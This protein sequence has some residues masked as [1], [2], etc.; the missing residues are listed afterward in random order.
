VFIDW[1]NDKD[2]DD[3]GELVATSASISATAAFTASVSVPAT[4]SLGA[5]RMR[6]VCTE[7][8]AASGVTACGT[9]SYGE[10]EDYSINI[11]EGT[12]T[13]APTVTSFTPASGAVGTSVTITGTNFTGA[14]AVR[15]NGTSATFTVASA[16][17]ITTSVPTGATTG[18]ISVTTA[19]GTANSASNFTVTAATYCA[20]N[21]TNSADSRINNVTFAG[22]NNSSTTACATYTNFTSLSANVLRS[23]S[24]TVSVT[25]GT[26]GGDY[27]KYGKVFIDWNKDGD[28]TDAG[29]TVATSTGISATAAFTAT[30]TVPATASLGAT[31]MRVV[32]VETSAASNVS[33]CGTYT[34]GE[35]EDYTVNIA[36]GSITRPQDNGSLV[37]TDKIE[38]LV[39]PNPATDLV[40]IELTQA[41]TEAK[42][43]IVNALGQVVYQSEI[44]ENRHTLDMS[45]FAS[46]L[47]LMQIKSSE[48][49]LT[50]RI[51]KR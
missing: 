35:T 34:Y 51:V 15:F 30:V 41:A 42:L 3:A 21:A 5:T 36:A 33:S 18:V 28:F 25:L 9:Y 44:S 1:N 31:R 48:G 17:S 13:P 10:T 11:S 7:A 2:F 49:E 43:V 29:E 46:G 38:V 19:G 24:Y 16:T 23:S 40:N 6:V 47:Y 50:E 14:T 26:C 22:I 12:P 20:S 32:C 39:Y 37:N 8:S 45:T 27:T 4:A